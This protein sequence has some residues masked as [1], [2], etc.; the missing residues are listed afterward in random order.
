MLRLL[1]LLLLLGG[2]RDLLL[3]LSLGE[4]LLLHLHVHFL[5]LNLLQ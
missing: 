5:L 3:K 1:L 4:R 2:R